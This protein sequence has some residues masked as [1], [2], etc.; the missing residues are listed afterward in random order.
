MIHWII[1]SIH[2]AYTDSGTYAIAI[3]CVIIA[4]VSLR[5]GDK[6]QDI[7]PTAIEAFLLKHSYL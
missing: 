1:I 5:K 7:I 6:R 4:L 2:S 3:S